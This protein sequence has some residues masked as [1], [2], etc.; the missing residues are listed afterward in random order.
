MVDL[1]GDFGER[2]PG[3][4]GD[5]FLRQS[6][7]GFRDIEAAVARQPGEEHILKAEDR[8]SASGGDIVHGSFELS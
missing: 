7:P 6:G 3:Q 1:D 8:S 5:G 2:P 4:A